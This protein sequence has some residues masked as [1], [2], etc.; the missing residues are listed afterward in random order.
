VVLHRLNPT[1]LE[2]AYFIGFLARHERMA[3]RESDELLVFVVR[4]RPPAI[5]KI[6]QTQELLTII[7]R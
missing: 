7:V 5:N 4:H 1:I 2:T 6:T 3:E